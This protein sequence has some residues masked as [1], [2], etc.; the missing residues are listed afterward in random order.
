MAELRSE[1]FG[2]EAIQRE[3]STPQWCDG[4]GKRDS[5]INTELLAY[6]LAAAVKC[7]GLPGLPV[8]RLPPIEIV[9]AEVISSEV[10]PDDKEGCGN[11]AAI[12]D[13][14][15]YVILVRDTLDMEKALDNSFLLHELVHVLQWTSR[16]PDIFKDCVASM[17][18]EAEAYRAQ[19]AYLKREGQFAR[20]GEVLRFTT[21]ARLQDAPFRRQTMVEPY[22]GPPGQA[23]N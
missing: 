19:N 21:C 6:L 5:V 11:L 20:F 7:S 23:N 1:C 12:F 15:H 3:R 14:E 17:R 22:F 9:S 13:T 4:R 8:E 10:C 16:G 18:T 2:A